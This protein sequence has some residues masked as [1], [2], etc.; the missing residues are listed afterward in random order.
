MAQP[1]ATYQD[2]DLVLKLYD[3]RREE[4][5]RAAR[6]WFTKDFSANSFGELLEKYP[7]KSS[8]Y[9]ENVIKRLGQ[10][11]HSYNEEHVMG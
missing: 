3:M 7:Q 10:P 1:H 5:L 2:A 6:A 4:K 11:T 8:K 9:K